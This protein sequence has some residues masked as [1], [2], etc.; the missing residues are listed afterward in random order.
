MNIKQITLTDKAA[1]DRY[2]D[3]LVVEID[4][5]Q[6]FCVCDGEPEDNNLYR[7][8]NDCFKIISLLKKAYKAGKNNEELNIEMIQV[9]E[10]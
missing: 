5:K 10:Y 4:G 2:G 7:N 3:M 6:N 9:D 8:F 1:M